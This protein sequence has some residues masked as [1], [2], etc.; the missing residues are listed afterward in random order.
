MRKTN[1]LMDVLAAIEADARIQALA[2]ELEETR[3]RLI[4]LAAP[5]F[6]DVL[7]PPR[8]ISN[9]AE[10]FAW[11]EAAMN[12]VLRSAEIVCQDQRSAFMDQRDRAFCPLCNGD[13]R[14]SK[15]WDARGYVLSTGLKRHL[16]GEGNSPM[17]KVASIVLEQAHHR[18]KHPAK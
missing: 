15:P 17:C 1:E 8:S 16:M 4:K 6:A 3:E 12:Q 7:N 9:G 14:G 5:E 18:W 10:A 2:N 13:R 11:F